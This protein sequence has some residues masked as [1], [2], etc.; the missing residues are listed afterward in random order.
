MY[1][2]SHGSFCKLWKTI[3]IFIEESGFCKKSEVKFTLPH[4][5]PHHL[6]PLACNMQATSLCLTLPCR[7][8]HSLCLA[9]PHLTS[10][11]CPVHLHSHPSPPCLLHRST[12]AHLAFTLYH[13]SHLALLT[14]SHPVLV[15]LTQPHS[16]SPSLTLLHPASLFLNQPHSSSLSL[17]LPHPASQPHSSSLSLSLYLTPR[18]HL[19]HLLGSCRVGREML[20]EVL[21]LSSSSSTDS[22]RQATLRRL[23]HCLEVSRGAAWWEGG[24]WGLSHQCWYSHALSAPFNRTQL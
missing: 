24:G 15:F 14:F 6:T 8:S 1:F 2:S 12:P 3:G 16:S 21:H 18:C 7:L 23:K 10:H 19:P 17:T 9:S 11:S 22:Q 13:S 4:S 5:A 20:D